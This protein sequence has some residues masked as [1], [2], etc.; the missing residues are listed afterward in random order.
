MNRLKQI[1]RFPL[2]LLVMR[3][4]AI[5]KSLGIASLV[6]TAATPAQGLAQTRLARRTVAPTKRRNGC[7]SST[8]TNGRPK[9]YHRRV[10]PVA[11]WST[12][13]LISMPLLEQYG[14]SLW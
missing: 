9:C 12:T 8:P 6:T 1:G 13:S 14:Y 3:H 10:L 2:R 7:E 5:V 11:E 4:V